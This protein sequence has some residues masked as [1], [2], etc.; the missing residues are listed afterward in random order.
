[1]RDF[2]IL[3]L[4]TSLLAGCTSAGRNGYLQSNT[5]TNEIAKTNLNLGIEYMRIGNY[6]KALEKLNKA[7]DAD[8]NYY[9]THNAYGLLYER[10]GK[11]AEAERHFKRAIALNNNDS[12]SKNNYGLFLCQSGRYD[13]AEEIFLSA[14]NNPLYN[15]PE[16]AITNAGTCALRANKSDLAENYFRRAL[17]RNPSVGAALI[18]M[19]QI[20]YDQNKYMNARGFL[21]R[22]LPVSRHTPTN[23]ALGIKIE[24]EL[25]DKNA[26]SSYGLLLRNNFPD[27]MEAK[28]NL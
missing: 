24:E 11:P 2:F 15:E 22:F 26:V 17:S 14:A 18:Q 4:T 7:Y 6:E 27:S 10:L 3:L 16:V 5:D 8:R 9:S 12:R 19:A 20:T 23:L 13:E 28:E 25:G 21:Q 1:M